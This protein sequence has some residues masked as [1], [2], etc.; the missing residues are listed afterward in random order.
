MITD[1]G[2]E[3]TEVMVMFRILTHRE[4]DALQGWHAS[5]PGSTVEHLYRGIYVLTIPAGGACEETA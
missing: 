1:R 3:R 2:P 5:C 4:W